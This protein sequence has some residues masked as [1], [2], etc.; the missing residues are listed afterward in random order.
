MP[1]E[2]T[3]V[4][5]DAQKDVGEVEKQYRR[6]IITDGERY[7]K[8]V[9]IWTHSTDKISNIMYSA[10][11]HNEGRAEHVHRRDGCGGNRHFGRDDS[12]ALLGAS[13][14]GDWGMSFDFL[15]DARH[16][17]DGES[18]IRTR[19]SLRRQHHRIGA[20]HDGVGDVA[21]LGPRWSWVLDHR[22]QHLRGGDHRT[23]VTIGEANDSLL[24]AG[25]GFEWQL[26][27]KV[28]ARNHDR[29]AGTN[30][31][32]DVM[33]R[34]VLLDLRHD[35]QPLGNHLPKR[36]DVLSPSYKA[37][38]EVIHFLV[39]GEVDVGDILIGD[40]WSR[41]LDTRQI[42][43]FVTLEIATIQHA[44][45]HSCIADVERNKLDQTIVDEDAIA[46][47]NVLREL[48]VGDGNLP[49]LLVTLVNEDDVFANLEIDWAGKITDSDSGALQITEDGDR[50]ASFFREAA[51]HGDRGGVLLVG[52]VRE[53]HAGHVHTRLDQPANR[54]IARG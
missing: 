6:G 41:D 23:P 18:W 22:L 49:V 48:I 31:R 53:I 20:I 19:G 14:R 3:D 8:I 43:A 13:E 47:M 34:D 16:R 11:E 44:R 45:L 9:D 28:T 46:D 40:R 29:I 38:G 33:E 39:D 1:K 2:K 52:A 30:D 42:H 12:I 24:G 36:L 50:L 10:M 27:P 54:F 17:F 25:Y 15:D 7:N 32:F 35:Q 37:K 4:I 21:G 51:N 26:D 5:E